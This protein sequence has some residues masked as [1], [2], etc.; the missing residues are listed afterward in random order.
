MSIKIKEIVKNKYLFTA[1]GLLL[2]GVVIGV[3]VLKF[4]P[5]K[6]ESQLGEFVLKD[7]GSVLKAA[8]NRFAL[9]AFTLLLLYIGG[10]NAVGHI[11][12]SFALLGF[13]VVYGIKNAL[14]FSYVGSD[15]IIKSVADYFTFSLYAAFLVVTMAESSLLSSQSV[16]NKLNKVSTEKPLYNAKN[17]TVKFIT[18]TAVIALFSVFSGY[19]STI[20]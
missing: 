4:L 5:E 7:G 11:T 2:A 19:I 17:Q 8:M 20:I 16:Y 12:V 6:L 3:L 9:P 14:N 18:F 10:F 15:F 1:C 13:G